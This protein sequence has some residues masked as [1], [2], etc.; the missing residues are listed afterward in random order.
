M[1]LPSERTSVKLPLSRVHPDPDQP[2]KEFDWD[3]LRELAASLRN[4]GQWVDVIVRPHSQMAED[5]ILV[6]G[7]RR[8][9]AMPLVPADSISATVVA[10]PLDAGQLLM[11]QMS[12]GLTSERLD[13]LEVGEGSQ[14]LMQMY[15]L[16][17]AGLAERLGTTASTITKIFRIVEGIP[18]E[19][20]PDVKSGALPF[21]VAYHIAR[22]KDVPTQLD[23]AAKFKA[24]LLKRDSVEASVRGILDP[25]SARQKKPKAVT[26]RTL[27]GLVAVLPPLDHEA[28]LAELACLVEAVKRC[29]RLGLQLSSVPQLL[30]A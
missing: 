5:Y 12:L 14:K 2:R 28:I 21:T 8:W 10:G 29:H 26:A 9:R 20:R 16:S 23:I 30:K 3:K 4:N 13:V 7:E 22:L 15:G 25:A 6:D 17:Y 1:I 27:R 19:L 18:E 11:T 24:G